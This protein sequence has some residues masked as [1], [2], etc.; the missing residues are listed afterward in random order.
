MLP[1]NLENTPKHLVIQQTVKNF[2]N[3][4]MKTTQIHIRAT[5]EFK[6]QLHNDAKQN[7][8]TISALLVESYNRFKQADEASKNLQRVQIKFEAT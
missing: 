6:Q 8:T 3:T 2:I 1:S 5:K 4:N 7:N